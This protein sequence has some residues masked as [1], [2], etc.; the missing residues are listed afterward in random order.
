MNFNFD[1]TAEP[2][3]EFNNAEDDHL[4]FVT[5]LTD[6]DIIGLDIEELVDSF[7]KQSVN[8][9]ESR[10]LCTDDQFKSKS[11]LKLI[12]SNL[13]TQFKKFSRETDK[14]GC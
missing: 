10:Q 8:V 11:P 4:G 6:K 2:Y 13:R 3:I 12:F 14:S 5:H 1:N 9:M 7:N